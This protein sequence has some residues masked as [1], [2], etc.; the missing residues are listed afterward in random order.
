MGEA[1]PRLQVEVKD[2]V[3][4]LDHNGKALKPGYKNIN[5]STKRSN[6][7]GEVTKIKPKTKGQG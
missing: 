6:S 7:R 2:K 5:T 4:Q 1:I 3:K